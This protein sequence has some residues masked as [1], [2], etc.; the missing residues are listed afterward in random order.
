MVMNKSTIQQQYNISSPITND[1][2]ITSPITNDS[3]ISSP[4]TN[5]S[6]ILKIKFL[7]NDISNRINT[8]ASILEN[9][10]KLS[11]VKNIPHANSIIK[12]LHGIP[13]NLDTVK[14]KIAQQI[15]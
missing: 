14:R 6:N 10:S 12:T 1:S 4:I 15:I 13:D 8:I 5:D 11:D 7:A 9:T 3:N 2:N